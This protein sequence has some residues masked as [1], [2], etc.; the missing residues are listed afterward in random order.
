MSAEPFIELNRTFFE[1]PRSYAQEAKED[2]LQI[3]DALRLKG[4]RD[5]NWDVLLKQYRVILLAE[6]G[7]GKTI[8]IRETARKLQSEGKAAFFIRLENVSLGLKEALEGSSYEDFQAWLVSNDEGW[9]FLDSVDEAR[10]KHALDFEQ[11]VIKIAT[12]LQP[13]MQ[14]IHV[15]ITG[16]V[17]AWKPKSD[18]Q[19][20]N[21]R[22][23][24]KD[25]EESSTEEDEV[26]LSQDDDIDD[27]FDTGNTK[28]QEKRKTETEF[29][30]Y[31]ISNLD[32]EQVEKF[33]QG[34]A[35]SNPLEFLK[36]MDRKDV[37][38]Q[39]GRPQDLLDLINFWVKH[40]RIGSRLE[41]IENSIQRRLE[42]RRANSDAANPISPDKLLDGAKL[43]AAAT[44]LM[45]VSN[46]RVID[47]NENTIGINIRLFL[48]NWTTGESDII[49]S[50][51]I[52]NNSIYGAVRFYHRSAREYLTA[53]W[54]HDCLEKGTSRK[55]VENLFFQKKY[56]LKVLIPSMRPILA[57][58]VL[59]DERIR[60]K[61][62][63]LEPEIVFEGGDPSSL[64]QEVRSKILADVCLKIAMDTSKHSATNYAAVQRFANPDI[65]NDIKA[66]IRQYR[67]RNEIAYFLVR[68]IWQ[69][70]IH[71]ALPEAKSFALDS[72]TEKYIRIAAIRAVKELGSD[73]DFQAIQAALLSQVSEIDRR[74]LGEVIEHLPPSPDAV[75]WIVKALEKVKVKEKFSSD[76]LGHSLVRFAESLT[77][78]LAALFSKHI[79]NFLEREPVIEKR[80]CMVSERFGWLMNCGARAVETLISSRHPEALC[81]ESLSILSKIPPFQEYADSEGRSL[82]T[83]IS[84]LAKN[85]PDLN[86]ALFWKD[87]E[88]TRE[89][90][91]SKKEKA[92]TYFWQAY[93]IRQYWNFEAIDFDRVKE[94][95]LKRGF[96]D[97]KLVALSLAF[98]IYKENDR[99]VK[100]REQLK[101]LVEDHPELKARLDEFLNP[102]AQTED[103]KKLKRQDANWKQKEK[104]RKASREKYHADWLAWLNKNFAKLK[105]ESL[106]KETFTKDRYLNAQ[107]YLLERMRKLKDDSTHWTRGNWQDLIEGFGDNIA[108][109]FRDGLLL[110]WR[111]YQPN[112]R[113]ESDDEDGTPIAVILGLSGLEIEATEI[114]NWP[115]S[116]TK[117]EAGLACRYAFHEL[118][119]FPTWFHKLHQR[120]PDVVTSAILKEIDWELANGQDGK[121][122]HYIID[123]VSWSDQ[124]LWSGIAPELL[125]RLEVEPSSSKY[126][127]YLLKVIQSN[128]TVSDQ[129][130]AQIAEEKC[131]TLN[132]L[133]HLAQWYAAWIGVEPIFAI[134]KLSKFLKTIR[135]NSEAVHFAMS[136]VVNLVGERRTGANARE[137]FKTP[138]HLKNIYLLM[139]KYIKAEEDIERAGKG[140]YSPELRDNAQDARNSL[141]AA[142]TKIP[143]EETYRALV[144]LYRKHPYQRARTWMMHSARELAEKDADLPAM[145]DK[146]FLSFKNSLERPYDD[147]SK[148]LQLKPSFYGVG[149]NLN[150][151][152]TAF[153]R[154]R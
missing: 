13:A 7:S 112:L 95:I 23:P 20:C 31:S 133:N 5:V 110:S 121:E 2:D 114:E 29:K 8:E 124:T 27:I 118:N 54:L 130:I 62:C 25:S 103:Q 28:S 71:K 125:K 116:L 51:P 90:L 86:L 42:E 24:F 148:F 41:L 59:F 150:D 80:F 102:P 131:R 57:W 34:R 16:R 100:W 61:A 48:S 92:L 14:R 153:K 38:D 77:P 3:G 75:E 106:L 141:F 94:D 139:H 78:D 40:G 26:E 64:P 129:Q 17:D 19:F 45:K 11:A 143:G 68:M 96:L 91:F 151:M 149:I 35:V 46:I 120:F 137:A 36:E 127:S 109:A 79:N 105:D 52:F 74:V 104:K 117:E 145:T 144:E 115:D 12:E 55:R 49:I 113:S 81:A 101:K 83:E 138:K 132:D 21:S 87:V 142:L 67:R 30:A 15:M 99:P 135:E 134:K 39:G 97:D 152:W 44:T 37:W 147:W 1:L 119:G 122:K 89:N 58:L 140:V 72:E 107:Y 65:A 123:K 136:T 63:D 18:F 33:I 22:F 88:V 111:L 32:R 70:R 76:G 98:Q 66:L 146:E 126:L 43:I 154:R 82:T 50:R 73:I 4:G 9:L 128:A 47:G 84:V 108:R 53:K 10:L 93:T 60:K 85:W 69:G 56:G 6:A